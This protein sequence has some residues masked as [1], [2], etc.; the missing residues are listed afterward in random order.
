VRPDWTLQLNSVIPL[1]PAFAGSRA[2]FAAYDLSAGA[3]RWISDVALQ[4]PPV[5][6]DDLIFG[7]EPN[8]LVAVRDADGA[9]AWRLPFQEPLA[10]PLIWDAGWLVAATTEGRILA[11]RG[12]DGTLIWQHA[13]GA[14]VHARPSFGGDRVYVPLE[15]ARLIALQAETGE[16]LWTR[17]LGGPA[18]DV[19]ALDDRLYVGSD[20]NFFY[21]LQTKNGETA[22][23][24]RTGGDVRGMPIVDDQRVYFV[25]LDNVLRGLDRIS[26]AQRWKRALPL[27]PT[28]GIAQIGDVLLVSGRSARVSGFYMKDGAPAGDVTAPGELITPPHPLR[29]ATTLLPMVTV[30]ANDIAK[31]TIVA[32]VIRNVEPAIAPAAPLPNPVAVP[33]T[34][35]LALDQSSNR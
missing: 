27:R 28:G 17:T 11:F 12:S 10:V 31:G 8:A 22:W 2:Y 14:P 3:L 6:G 30:V 5:A 21:C 18:N 19:L 13:A 7:V 23:R 16:P 1:P 24:W 35:P 20:D 9:I 15:D 26:G 29:S 33:K 4:S 34:L 32:A 25:S